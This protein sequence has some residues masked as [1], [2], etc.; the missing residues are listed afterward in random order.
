[1]NDKMAAL[2]LS[3]KPFP[4]LTTQRLC[5]RQF[6]REDAE[7][8]LKL[9]TNDRV[10]KYLGRAKM[11]SVKEAEDFI[12]KVRKDALENHSVEWA[13]SM[14][15]KLIGKLGFWRIMSQHRRAELGYNLMPDYFRKGLMSEAVS[16]VLK[17]GFEEIGLHSVEANLDPANTKSSNL[18][19]RNGFTREGYFKESYFFDGAFTDTASYSLLKADWEK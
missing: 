16:A 1:M 18:L 8:L 7:F 17:Y 12:Q 14:E 15:G 10:M 19:K 4:E 13:I 9:R 5:L 6:Q 3:F 11:S 2:N